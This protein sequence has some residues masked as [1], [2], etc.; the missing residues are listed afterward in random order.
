MASFTIIGAGIGGLTA[1]ISLKKRH[2]DYQLYE[3]A[4]HME[5]IGAGIILANNAMQVYERLGLKDVLM[6][7]GHPVN[8]MRITNEQLRPL[9]SIDLSYFEQQYGVQNIA[10][11]RGDLQQVLLEQLDA[12][13]IYLDHQLVECKE[14]AGKFQLTFAGNKEIEVSY[15]IGADGLHSMVRKKLFPSSRIR[16][17]RQICWRGVVAFDL[18][19]R[20]YHELNEAWGKGTRFGFVNLGRG[21]VYWYALVKQVG[22]E[23]KMQQ[24]E[25]QLK[26]RDYHPLVQ[27]LMAATSSEHIHQSV[28]QDLHPLS[29]WYKG[30]M[31]LLGDAAHA[32]TPNLGQG[33]C[34]AIEDAWVLSTCLTKY[35]VPKAFERYQKMRM[36]KARRVVQ[37][38]W[39]LGKV[40]HWENTVAVWL[41]NILLEITPDQAARQQSAALFKIDE[42]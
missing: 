15:V 35:A 28:I 31:C 14:E 42:L 37:T 5:P 2:F 11:H 1:A 17:A 3:Q 36:P 16:S 8:A 30:N 24:A 29:K 4:R 40:A 23:I 12:E 41:R 39:R 25:W 19:Q 7:Q 6:D 21:K 20:Y 18:P 34:Q 33:A 32:T 10:I 9:S 22:D 13:K 26:F 38:S 27:R